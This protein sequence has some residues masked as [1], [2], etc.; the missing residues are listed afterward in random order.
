MRINNEGPLDAKLDVTIAVLMGHNGEFLGFCRDAR[1]RAPLNY[2]T[3]PSAGKMML[4]R[5]IPTIDRNRH[6]RQ[7]HTGRREAAAQSY[8]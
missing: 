4:Y 2:S 7:S 5:P 6:G 8:R 1:V 3:V